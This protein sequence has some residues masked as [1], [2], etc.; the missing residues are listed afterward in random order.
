MSAG[1]MQ[2]ADIDVQCVISEC[3]AALITEE[4]SYENV[5]RRH[6]RA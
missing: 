3:H 5:R 1:C 2:L 4:L 6:R